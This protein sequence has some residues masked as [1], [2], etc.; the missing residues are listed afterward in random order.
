MTTYVLDAC[1]IIALLKRENGADEVDNLFRQAFK[2]EVTL[3]VSIV[4]LLEVYYGFVAD[5]GI[6]E[7]VD[8]LNAIDDTP[9]VVIDV[10]SKKVYHEAARLKGTYRRLSLADAVGIATAIERD[11]VFVTSDHHELEVIQK[12]VIIGYGGRPKNQQHFFYGFARS[13][14][15]KAFS[16]N[17]V[18]VGYGRCGDVPRNLPRFGKAKNRVGTRKKSRL[19][20]L[21]VQRNIGV[22]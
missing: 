1:A 13:R 22:D 15:S 18:N 12:D 6:D 2:G 7:T 19:V 10:I 14:F 17:I 5:I 16:C 4:N 20:K 8:M 11:G 3:C 21:F 9:L